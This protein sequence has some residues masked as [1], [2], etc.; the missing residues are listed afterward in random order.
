MSKNQYKRQYQ[1]LGTLLSLCSN[2]SAFPLKIAVSSLSDLTSRST[3]RVTTS[4]AFL[5]SS[6]TLASCLAC[7]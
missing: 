2:S 3:L 6:L 1:H 7:S 4:T 5:T